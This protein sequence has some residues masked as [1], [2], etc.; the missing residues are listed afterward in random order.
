M[1]HHHR[2]IEGLS[3]EGEALGYCPGRTDWTAP[4]ACPGEVQRIRSAEV[5]VVRNRH[6]VVEVGGSAM[7]NQSEGY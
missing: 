1:G 6:I 7:A 2:R 4:L 5:V 3:L